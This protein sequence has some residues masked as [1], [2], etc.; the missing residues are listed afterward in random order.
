MSITAHLLMYSMLIQKHNGK[1]IVKYFSEISV[2]Y[3]VLSSSVCNILFQLGHHF[4]KIHSVNQKQGIQ[5]FSYIDSFLVVFFFFYANNLFIILKFQYKLFSLEWKAMF[6][7]RFSFHF[8]LHFC[9]YF[10]GTCLLP[11]LILLII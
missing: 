5:R 2:Q 4:I 11:T 10:Q 1:S 7:M 3:S 9:Y 8:R 6:K